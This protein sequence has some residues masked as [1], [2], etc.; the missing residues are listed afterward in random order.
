MVEYRLGGTLY[1]R[2][3]PRRI[4]SALAY[5]VLLLY[6]QTERNQQFFVNFIA[7][8]FFVVYCPKEGYWL[9]ICANVKLE[10]L[11]LGQVLIIAHFQCL[12]PRGLYLYKLYK[13]PAVQLNLFDVL[14]VAEFEPSMFDIFVLMAYFE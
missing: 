8:Y 7:Y 10:F 1:Q 9:L 12:I 14:E 4:I 11:A 5:H 3:R 6:F 2:G 13:F